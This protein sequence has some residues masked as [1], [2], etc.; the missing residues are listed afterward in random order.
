MQYKTTK[1]KTDS[2][3]YNRSDSTQTP[4]CY[5]VNMMVKTSTFFSEV[6]P[7][8]LKTYKVQH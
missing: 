3:N 2:Q 1:K 5:V 7:L 8:C 4:F 6:L